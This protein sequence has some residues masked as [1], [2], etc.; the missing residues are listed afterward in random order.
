MSIFNEK[1]ALFAIIGLMVI[2][3]STPTIYSVFVAP[4]GTSPSGLRS[5]IP[6]DIFVYFSY[7]EQVRQGNLMLED[8][9]TTE[10][11]NKYIN[12]FW[13]FLGL[14]SWFGL[15]N[16]AIFL[17][18]RAVL[19]G[20]L[21]Y[22][23]YRVL[24]YFTKEFIKTTSLLLYTLF[25][26]GLGPYYILYNTDSYYL[27]SPLDIWVPETNLIIGMIASPHNIASMILVLL[28]F[29]FGYRAFEERSI[30][31]SSIAGIFSLLLF[32]FHPYYIPLIYMV[33]GAYYVADAMK[34]R[35]LSMKKWMQV[36]LPLLAISL[37]S[38][39]YHFYLLN[40]DEVFLSRA[41][42]NVLPLPIPFLV[43]ISFSFFLP[44]AL[45]GLYAFIQKREVS[46][47]VLF[48]ITWFTVQGLLVVSPITY[49]RK[50]LEVWIVPMAFLSWIGIVYIV[51]LVQKKYSK[52]FTFSAA[53]LIMF[54]LLTPSSFYNLTRDY[55]LFANKN[56]PPA[57][58]EILYISDSKIEAYEWIIENTSSNDVFLSHI[59]SG[60]MLPAFTGRRV[61]VGHGSETIYSD[62]QKVPFM[63]MFFTEQFSKERGREF[64]K[65]NG[66]TH[67]WW[68]RPE[69]EV[70]DFE[71]SS[72]E[73]LELIFENDEVMVYKVSS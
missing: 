15:S 54:I 40:I 73:Y 37:P 35:L 36:F 56:H 17:I 8:L 26:G 65:N 1:K 12:V 3:I 46:S 2:L 11:S 68:S 18:S 66:I 72:K 14:F 4:T 38:V 67:I 63:V 16:F 42:A 41:Y 44:T 21:V 31:N 23:L 51:D 55:T 43:L 61:Y 20:V 39:V 58:A 28:I 60:T 13:Q 29:Y 52:K 57:T 34:Q 45:L 53:A 69:A 24:S 70:F 50:L 47:K 30:F 49:Q 5:F 48:L 59:N 10:E 71:I 19:T 32:Q 6:G 33:L 9:Y 62:I 27:D 25:A 22:I 7:L 64:L